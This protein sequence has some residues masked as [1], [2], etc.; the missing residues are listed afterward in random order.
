MNKVIVV[1]LDDMIFFSRRRKKHP[2]DLKLI[3]QECRNQGISLNPKKSIFCVIEGKLLGHIVLE[4]GI[5]I[6]PERVQAIQQLCFPSHRSGI[7]S[8]FKKINF[9]RRFLPDFLETTRPMVNLLSEKQN[10]R[11]NDEAKK[12]FDE[13]KEAIAQ[14]PILSHSDFYKDF[15][16]HCY[17]SE[18]IMAGVLLQ[19]NKVGEEMPISFMIVHLKN[20]EL[21]YSP[22]EK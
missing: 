22:T 12:S 10:F 8:F 15:V 3:L 9:L 18:H 16:I 5:A 19:K 20:H 6:D 13:V 21:K 4:K 1:Y 2:K 14:A 11:W 7:R 17:A